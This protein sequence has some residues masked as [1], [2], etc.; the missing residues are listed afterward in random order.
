[1]D[2]I[3]IKAMEIGYAHPNGLTYHQLKEKIE[4]SLN[5]KLLR[6]AEYGLLE[7]LLE[8][9]T[10]TDSL[11]GH[12]GEDIDPNQQ[13][14][15]YYKTHS[16][17]LAL[18]YEDFTKAIYT[19]KGLTV[20]L[21]LD[22]VELKQSREQANRAFKTSLWSIG[23]ALLSVL[24]SGLFY[25]FSSSPISPPFDVNIIE[26]KSGIEEIKEENKELKDKL[27]KAEILIDLLEEQD[28]KNSKRI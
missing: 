6:N 23:I 26:D 4:S 12:H 18:V 21:Y 7:W 27:Y 8:S 13:V 28:S 17:N 5:T 24:L 3:Y 15:K 16:A 9:F 11:R 10:T 20:K 14:L 2:N 1:M 19:I 25:F 22:Y